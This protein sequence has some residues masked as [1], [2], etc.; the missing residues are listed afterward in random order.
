MELWQGDSLELMRSIPD[1]SVAA[2]QEGRDFIGIELDP[3][4]FETARRRIDGAKG[5][6]L[7]PLTGVETA[8]E[9]GTAAG[10][11]SMSALPESGKD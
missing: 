6:G 1:A 5:G 9:D 4:Y 10:S 3:E 2:L 7:L 11:L 8:P